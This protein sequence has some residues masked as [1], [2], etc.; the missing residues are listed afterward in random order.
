[1]IMD[2]SSI[3]QIVS[4]G[5]QAGGGLLGSVA[6]LFNQRSILKAQQRENMLNRKFNAE[7]AELS[8][9]FASEQTEKQNFYNSASQ[10]VERLVEAGLNPAVMYGSSP[11]NTSDFLNSSA[12]ASS[13]GSVNPPGLDTSGIVSSSRAYAETKLLEAQARLA[14]ANARK[15]N[16]ETDWLPIL[17]DIELKF[18]ES[19]ITLNQEQR[20]TLEKAGNLTDSQ[21]DM[22]IKSLDKV[23]EEISNLKAERQ[24]IE[25]QHQNYEKQN[26]HLD[27]I[28]KYADE[29]ERVRIENMISST[30]Y[31]FANANL[32]SQQ[33]F[34]LSESARYLISTNESMSISAAWQAALDKSKKNPHLWSKK[35][36]E[37]LQKE[38]DVLDR[39]AN[40]NAIDWINAIS[41]GVGSLT[42]AAFF[43]TGTAIN[44]GKLSTR[45]VKV[46]FN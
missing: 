12:T 24:L 25:S 11:Q 1:M 46:G 3:S 36:Y 7:Q 35:E 43:G 15:A 37:R 44:V 45:A 6:S 33:A 10:Q 42:G 34:I 19:G 28:L 9:K 38:I 39:G 17:N 13:S 22:V 16:T 41:N 21:R 26:M 31:L 2:P 23:S 40:G 20:S 5:I 29:S 30:K 14:D 18:K 8:R 4:S 32:T 27:V